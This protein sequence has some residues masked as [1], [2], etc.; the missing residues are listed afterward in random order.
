GLLTKFYGSARLFEDENLATGHIQGSVA[1]QV[2]GSRGL[3]VQAAIDA[4]VSKDNSYWLPSV[5]AWKRFRLSDRA[6]LGVGGQVGYITSQ[7][8]DLSGGFYRPYVFGDWTFL[9][10]A[11][12][13]ARVQVEHLNSRNDYYSYVAPRYDL[14]AALRI[15]GFGLTPQITITQTRYTQSDA[16]WGLT[17]KDLTLR[18]ALTLSHDK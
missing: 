8:Q 9:P 10:N 1:R 12:A 7:N 11:T 4:G 14:G 2:P 5:E 16:F 3:F 17:R 13:F 15:G 18:P 6:G